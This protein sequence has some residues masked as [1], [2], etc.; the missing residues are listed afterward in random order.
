[1]GFPFRQLVKTIQ[2]SIRML[3]DIEKK[4]LRKR[5][6]NNVKVL[7]FMKTVMS[8]SIRL[9]GKPGLHDPLISINFLTNLGEFVSNHV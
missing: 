4:L 5:L 1:M 9:S 7:N 6:S 3:F 8:H 2:V